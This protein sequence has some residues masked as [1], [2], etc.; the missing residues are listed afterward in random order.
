[1][2]RSATR[3]RSR[4]HWPGRV[5][6]ARPQIGLARSIPNND[7]HVGVEIVAVRSR[8]ARHIARMP[9]DGACFR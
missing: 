9:Q 6:L 8:L 2:M 1:M 4:T 3:A 5:A 7:Q